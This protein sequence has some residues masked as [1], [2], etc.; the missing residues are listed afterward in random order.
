MTEMKSSKLIEE[1]RAARVAP[2]QNPQE[3]EDESA[4]STRRQQS[5]SRS[6]T[7]YKNDSAW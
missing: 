1:L 2:K 5:G 6:V 7:D 4:H 3:L